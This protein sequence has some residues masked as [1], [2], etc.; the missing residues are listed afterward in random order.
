MDLI[1]NPAHY[2]HPCP[3]L[4]RKVVKLLE[5]WLPEGWW[6]LECL[7]ALEQC[8]ADGASFAELSAIKYLWRYPHKGTPVQDLDKACFYLQREMSLHSADDPQYGR[9]V[10]TLNLVTAERQRLGDPDQ[11]K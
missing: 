3:P 2:L 4:G 7:E 1:N 6:D 11:T 10:E 9:L 5:M 8:E